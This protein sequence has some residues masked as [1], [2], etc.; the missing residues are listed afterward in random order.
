[1]ESINLCNL[2]LAS[3]TLFI[4]SSTLNMKS[5]KF[6]MLSVK[7]FLIFWLCK[8]A[9]GR[10]LSPQKNGNNE[11]ISS[12]VKSLVVEINS[13]DSSTRD[14]AVLKFPVDENSRLRLDDIARSIIEALPMENIVTKPKMSD[15]TGNE[16]MRMRKA[17]VIIIIS[18]ATNGVRSQ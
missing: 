10:L 3:S 9:Q 1:M 5:F 18:D 14:V 8:F 15:V 6:K 13:K 7:I 12:L 11:Q 4:E 2:I 17:T 16:R